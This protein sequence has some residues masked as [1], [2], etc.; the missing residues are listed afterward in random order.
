MLT[1]LAQSPAK[2]GSQIAL[3]GASAE[4]ER[5]VMGVVL[6]VYS[7]ASITGFFD[8]IMLRFHVTT[9]HKCIALEAS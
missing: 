2:I 9:M 3:R 6:Q 1:R 4:G 7:G 8:A 5:R